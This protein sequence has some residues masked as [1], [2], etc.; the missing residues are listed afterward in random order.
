MKPF[1]WR[2]STHWPNLTDKGQR[3]NTNAAAPDLMYGSCIQSKA[4]CILPSWVLP[5]NTKPVTSLGPTNRDFASL[6]GYARPSL[7][8]CCSM[9]SNKD[10]RPANSSISLVRS[11]CLSPRTAYWQFLLVNV[12]CPTV[13]RLQLALRLRISWKCRNSTTLIEQECHCIA[14]L[15]SIPSSKQWHLR[16]SCSLIACPEKQKES[17]VSSISQFLVVMWIETRWKSQVSHPIH[18]CIK[19]SYAFISNAV[20][21]IIQ[22]RLLRT[23][24]CLNLGFH[25]YLTWNSCIMKKQHIPTTTRIPVLQIVNRLRAI[26]DSESEAL[27]H[28]ESLIITISCGGIVS[29]PANEHKELEVSPFKIFHGTHHGFSETMV[30]GIKQSDAPLEL[31]VQARSFAACGKMRDSSVDS[32][33][34]R[35]SSFKTKLFQVAESQVLDQ[36]VCQKVQLAAVHFCLPCARARVSLEPDIPAPVYSA[37]CA[38]ESTF[39]T[40]SNKR[41]LPMSGRKLHV[42]QY[43][44]RDIAR[45]HP[46]TL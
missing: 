44:Q 15:F 28:H 4:S 14:C 36:G 43:R 23:E 22:H 2:S 17:I 16:S 1:L 33:R 20:V 12:S 32:E 31:P 3:P 41:A 19:V 8:T 5:E 37:A 27:K 10:W 9:P 40:Y 30:G 29:K 24:L 39:N 18:V 45:H 21:D 25:L 34:V 35:R 11:L 38:P 26:H 42:L 7:I 6:T 46:C 13:M